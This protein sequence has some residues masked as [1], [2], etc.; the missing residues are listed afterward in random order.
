MYGG[1]L[2]LPATPRAIESFVA[3]ADAAPDEVS[4]IAN[5]MPAP[6]LPFLPESQHGRPVVL[7]TIAYAGDPHDGE[8]ALEPFREID[9]PLA[10][11]LRPIRYPELFPPEPDDFHPI[12]VAR[13]GFLDHVALGAAEEIVVGLGEGSAAMNV[14]QLRVLG[15]AMARVPADATAFATPGQPGSGSRR[16]RPRTTRTTSSG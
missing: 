7:A 15:G 9:E 4:A 16:S 13:T 10:D 1:M 14:V 8:T 11:M 5:V 3:A 12:A 6:P 2:V